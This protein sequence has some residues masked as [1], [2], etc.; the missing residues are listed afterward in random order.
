M[1]WAA[2][3][4]QANDSVDAHETFR[5]GFMHVPSAPAGPAHSN[6]AIAENP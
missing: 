3:L 4:A 6:D 5:N 1:S 2:F